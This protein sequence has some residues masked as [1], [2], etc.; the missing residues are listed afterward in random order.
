MDILGS[1]RSSSITNLPSNIRYKKKQTGN[2]SFSHPHPVFRTFGTT[3]R[4][5][6]SSF[7]ILPGISLREMRQTGI[8]YLLRVVRYTFVFFGSLYDWGGVSFTRSVCSLFDFNDLPGWPYCLA[9]FSNFNRI[10]DIDWGTL[11]INQYSL[12]TALQ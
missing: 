3:H 8:L 12:S 1:R 6:P 10:F 2:S 7:L 5:I 9:H 4:W 11:Q